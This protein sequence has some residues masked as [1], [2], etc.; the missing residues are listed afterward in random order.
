VPRA[1]A[2]SFPVAVLA[3][4]AGGSAVPAGAATPTASYRQD[5]LAASPVSYWRLGE[6]SG[7][8]AADE[9]GTN[10]GTYSNVLLDQPGALFCDSNPSASFDGAQ[11]YMRVPASPSLDM[12]SGVT[13]EL[14]VKR[15][16]ISSTYQVLVGKPGNGV[17]KFENYAVWLAPSNKL[18]AYFGNGSTSVG[19]QTPPI[20]DTNWHHVVATHNGSTV[21]TYVDGAL[22]QEVATTVQLTANTEPL[23]LGRAN[24]NTYFFNGWLDEVAIYPT[25]LPA[26]T[27]QAHYAKGV[28]GVA[29][30]CL[31]LTT[32]AN[33]RQTANGNVTFSGTAGSAAGDLSAITVKLYAGATADG[34]PEQILSASRDWDNSY[35][36]STEVANG[37]WTAQAEQ[38]NVAGATGF[39]SANTFVVNS[40]PSPPTITS[41][42]PDLS[43]SASAS[44]EFSHEQ[45][46]VTFRCSLDDLEFTDCTSPQSYTDLAD[47]SHTF[48]VA[49]VDENGNA[50][51][52]ARRTWTVDTTPPAI[53]LTSPANGDSRLEWPT[54]TGTGGTAGGDASTA[55]VKLYPGSAPTGT[56][57]QTLPATLGTG[58]AY[59]VI[60]SAPLDPGTYTA[61]AEQSDS[62][63]NTGS[64]SA[65][66]FT[67]G[68]PVVFA[69]GSIASCHDSGASRT[70]NLLAGVPD[71]LVQLLGN[72]AYENGQPS[73][74]Q[75]CYDPTWGAAKA[76]TRPA[77]GNHDMLTLTGGPPAGTG[78]VNY[79][80]DQLAPL[81]Q[82]AGDLTK[83]YYSYDLGAWHIVVLNDTCINPNINGGTPGCDEAAQEQWLRNDLSTH[84]NDCVLAVSNRPRWSSD[85]NG[86]RVSEGVYWNIFYHYGVDLVLAGATHHYER[87]APQDPSG[88]LDLSYGIREIVSG[89]GGYASNALVALQPNSEA[90]DDTSYGVLKLTLHSGSYDWEF[91]PVADGV[92][93][94][95]GS[96]TDSG[97]SNCHGAPPVSL[98]PYREQVL[99]AS[100]AAY[101]RLGETSGTSATDEIGANPGTY[102]NVLLDQ[103]SA[104]FSDSNPS[105][106]FSGTQSYVRVPASPSLDMT[107]AAT[108][109]LWVK[110]RTISS[111]YQVLV[112]KPGN[113]VS[114][115]ENYAIWLAPSNKLTAYFGNGST[116]ASVQTPPITDT[117]W[118]HVVATHNGSKVSIYLDGVLKQVVTTTVQLTAN[119][120]PLNLGRSNTSTYFFNGWLDE[121][122]VYPAAL[123][124]QTILAHYNRGS[125]P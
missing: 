38:M 123:P 113:G 52:P 61:Q 26:T 95:G 122:A 44:F 119:T 3:L 91:V 14:W 29:P 60:A 39:S 71:A 32:P 50:G 102:N 41:A 53:E 47:G 46:G 66:T 103:T 124:A 9:T 116:A 94:G 23:N 100:P 22:K 68:D 34:T 19:V 28:P 110:R 87:F 105:A 111:T 42:P 62:V 86:N 35:S 45:T 17:S 12:T 64:S 92:E 55:T 51:F 58:G 63:G 24:N 118:H 75:G 49:A 1:I 83:L 74:Y 6:T 5:A 70:A 56:P 82:S 88:N 59:A 96:F 77:V 18:T 90:Y 85:G 20:T 65:N 57:L 7:T 36:V 114:K 40:G 11:S 72:N 106:S 101:W 25:A 112:G 81:G 99:A 30:P 115:F 33:G 8:S 73:D 10:P 107:S 37:T 16:T 78:Y 31:S 48:E 67:V 120:Q 108:V 79:F 13:V 125:N 43:G 69:A 104:L 84:P 89:H 117:N 80:G 27:I 109:E 54:F 2:L 21:R 15:R 97:S 93:P 98:L 4:L 76:R 121:V